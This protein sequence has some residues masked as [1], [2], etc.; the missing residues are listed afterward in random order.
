MDLPGFLYTCPLRLPPLLT[1][2]SLSTST[3]ASDSLARR[4]RSRFAFST[5]AV[6]PANWGQVLCLVSGIGPGVS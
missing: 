2:I 1:R 4:G 5:I 6:N 3:E